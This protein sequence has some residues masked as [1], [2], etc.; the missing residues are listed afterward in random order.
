[1]CLCVC[2]YNSTNLYVCLN[3]PQ[4]LCFGKY[5]DCFHHQGHTIDFDSPKNV[6]EDRQTFYCI[7]IPGETKWVKEVS[8]KLNGDS[9]CVLLIFCLW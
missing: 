2:L 3:L 6:T 4:M 9:E 1:M 8:S 7:P 5:T